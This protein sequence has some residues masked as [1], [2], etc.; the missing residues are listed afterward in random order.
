[1]TSQRD[2]EVLVI[3]TPFSRSQK[4]LNATEMLLK[5]LTHLLTKIDRLYQHI[6][7]LG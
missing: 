4:D 6:Q 5:E 1:M 2:D 7:G 3:L